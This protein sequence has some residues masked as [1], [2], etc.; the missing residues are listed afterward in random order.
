M[1]E[2]N[3][4]ANWFVRSLIILFCVVL[5]AMIAFNYFMVEP[6][7]DI[8]KGVIGLL[9]ILLVLVLAESFDNFSLGKLI[10]ISRDA[11]KKGDQVRDL[12]RKNS[13]LLQQLIT[14]SNTQSQTQSHTNVYGDY[15]QTPSAQLAFEQETEQ[16]PDKEEVEKLLSAVGDSG[17]IQYMVNQIT[18][19]LA[20][21]DEFGHSFRA[22]PATCSEDNRP[23]VPRQ[24]GHLV[25]AK[26]RW[27]LVI[28]QSLFC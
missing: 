7:G 4:S 9:S 10:S 24:I 26:R 16:K 23:P 5:A 25:G 22:I 18:D 13:E 14:I 11:K 21:S 27:Y 8:N 1:E 28:S 15:H 3:K 17:V 2:F 20:Y 19:E 12:K 6:K